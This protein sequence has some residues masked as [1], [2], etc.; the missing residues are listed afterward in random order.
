MWGKQMEIKLK[1]NKLVMEHQ[2]KRNETY[3]ISNSDK[4][5]S[6]TIMKKPQVVNGFSNITED[7]YSI[8][9]ID[10]DG[11]DKEVVLEDYR[12]IQEKFLLPPAYLLK[13]KE[14]NWHVICLKKFKHAEIPQILAYTR[15]DENYKTMAIR[16]PFRSY[17]LR[18]SNK[19]GS[20]RPE[21]VDMIGKNGNYEFEI[22]TAHKKL[23]EKL[24][25][26]SPKIKY[27]NEDK[28]EKIRLQSYQTGC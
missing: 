18:I 21:F 9:L 12:L 11:V 2:L 27:N 3:R 14:N 8:L 13:T 15:A 19:K 23:I 22:S 24:H 25:P 7:N 5:Q 28:H 10:Y 26:K 4:F 16:S 1:K 17:V 20:K 6:V